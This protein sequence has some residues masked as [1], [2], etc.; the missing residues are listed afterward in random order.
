MII[1]AVQAQ[2]FGTNC[3]VLASRRNSEA[4]LVDPGIGTGE[5][6]IERIRE[7]LRRDN[8]KPVAVLI[9]H[10]HLDH[11]FSL[12]PL[13]SGYGIP[14]MIHP[15][16]RVLL[17]NPWL[18]LTPGGESEK[19]MASLGSPT[20]T[21][22][23]QVIEVVDGHEFSIAGMQF[24]TLHAPG[25]TKGSTMF[26]VDDQYLISGDVL[27]AGSVGRTDLPY[28]SAAQMRTTLLT[29]VLIQ[30][31]DLVVLPGHGGQTTIG[32]ERKRNPFLQEKA[33]AE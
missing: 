29:K 23:E 4:I 19:L 16:D 12:L 15:Q 26:R 31:D 27:F 13:A 5:W 3:W 28:G 9:T 11:T 33:L 10:G 8:L 18:A 20:F 30:S 14:A 7:Q 24:T 2:F 21:E 22:P 25:H 1:E 6:M 17:T 32:R